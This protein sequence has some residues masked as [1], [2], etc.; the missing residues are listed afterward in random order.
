MET[1][2][3]IRNF[4]EAERNGKMP[5]TS[6][7]N[8]ARFEE[9]FRGFFSEGKDILYIAFSSA[10]SSTY[11]RALGAA[12]NIK[13]EFPDRRVVI[14]D[15]KCA[16]LGEGLLVYHAAKMKNSGKTIDEVAKW[17]EDN[18]LHLCHWFTVDDLH[19]LKRGGRVSA[20]SA[21]IG[22]MLGIKP[23]MHVDDEG[24]LI[25]VSKIR[26]RRHAI[27]ALIDKVE[28]TVIDSE[29]QVAFISHGDCPDD[30]K[31]LEQQL[32]K[33]FKFKEIITN[34]IGPVIGSHSGPGT[35]A[36]FFLGTER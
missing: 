11:S 1:G 20:A 3:R 23:V 25:L 30:A 33:R 13:D 35:I 7:I 8:E 9:I 4:Y 28:K 24:K 32:K 22:T 17:L 36:V 15:S 14:V 19:H 12:E 29:K 2:E 18:K 34:Y 6:Q 16:S 10:L 26:G 5:S 31:Y 21:V 27:D